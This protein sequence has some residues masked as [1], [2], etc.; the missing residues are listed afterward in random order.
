[1]RE[2]LMSQNTADYV[3]LNEQQA[4]A[5]TDS[6]TLNRYRQ[7]F[8]Y[9][10]KGTHRV[11]DVGCCTGR[12]GR[13]LKEL[14]P[15]LS[16]IG[17]DCVERRLALLPPDVY[18]G[19]LCSFS[20]DIRAQ[21]GSFDVIVAGEFIEHLVEGDVDQTLNELF[22]VLRPGGRAL[23]TTPNPRYLRNTLTGRTVLGGPH[24]SQHFHEALSSRLRR[25]GF[26]RVLIRGSGKVSN[27]L[28]AHFPVL[29]LYGSYLAVATK[30]EPQK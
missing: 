18:S 21:D 3:Q 19:G 7:F 1:M 25:V 15:S 24:L 17:L 5:E 11:L 10:P 27:F 2:M 13:I 29:R 26:A 30:P 22:R 16:I 28:G 12:G 14:D 8:R 23:L 9:F 20:T 4:I 6:F